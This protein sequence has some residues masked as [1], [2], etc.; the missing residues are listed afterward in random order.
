MRKALKD[1][2]AARW[3][4]LAENSAPL[5]RE[6]AAAGAVLLR[7]PKGDETGENGT[8]PP[9][10]GVLTAAATLPANGIQDLADRIPELTG[11]AVG[12]ALEFHVRVEFGGDRP[13]DP[14]TVARI[15]ELLAKV[16]NELELK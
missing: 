13:P 14:E 4:E 11:A 3:V 7:T 10:P 12:H 15:N 1:A 2:I 5:P 16:S 9:P 6:F 8:D